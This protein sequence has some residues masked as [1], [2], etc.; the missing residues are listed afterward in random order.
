MYLLV[1]KNAT[2]NLLTTVILFSSNANYKLQT[3]IKSMMLKL[4]CK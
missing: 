1:E 4:Y 2:P 3:Y